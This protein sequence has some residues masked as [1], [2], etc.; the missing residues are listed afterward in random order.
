[1]R[2][3]AFLPIAL[4]ASGMVLEVIA[5]ATGNTDTPRPAWLLAVGTGMLDAV[6]LA[7]VHVLLKAHQAG[8]RQ[9][10]GLFG[11]AW[12]RHWAMAA[13]LTVPALGLAWSVHQ[14]CGWFLE[15]L[16][17]PHDPQAAVEAI[18]QTAGP[19][20]RG[21]LFFFAVL[22][23]PVAEEILFRGILWPLA[24]DRGWRVTGCLGVSLL[25]SLI[26]LNA[27]ALIP[28][29]LLGIFWTWL[30]ERTGDL[31]TC[32][33]SHAL[34]NGTNFIWMLLIEPGS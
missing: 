9:A 26:H 17:I 25:F 29:W 31:T 11:T 13:V 12:P 19:W 5:R 18:R 1:V 15:H 23:A 24:R 7:M 34:F 6:G 10:F 28:L 3:L 14:A 33:L 30:Y 2:F 16:A 27:A 20:D 32:I 22:T 4:A 21:L 8:W